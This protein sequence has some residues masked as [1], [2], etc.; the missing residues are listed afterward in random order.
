MAFKFFLIPA[1]WQKSDN[2]LFWNLL[3]QVLCFFGM[4]TNHSIS[5]LE[6]L[7]S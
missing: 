7:L 2:L 4:F 6:E 1:N 5:I 3:T